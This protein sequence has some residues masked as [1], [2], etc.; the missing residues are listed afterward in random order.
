M[1]KLTLAF[2]A[3]MASFCVVLGQKCGQTTTPMRPNRRYDPEGQR[4]VGGVEAR[5]GSHPWIVSMQQYGSHFCGGTLIRVSDKKEQSDIVVT[6]A[7]CVYDGTSRLEVVAGAHDLDNKYSTG[8]Q[9]VKAGTTKYHPAYNSDTTMNDIAIIKLDTPIN[10]TS[11]VQPACL[12]AEEE[13]VADNTQATVAGWGLTREGGAYSSNILMQVGVP[14]ISSKDCGSQYKASGIKI[15]QSAM[16]CAGYKQ[17]G[18][19]A[20][21]GDSGGPFVVQ[22]ADKGYTLQGVVSFGVG[23]AR[24]GLPGVYT[25]V[26]TYR[27]WIN[28][29]I[30]LNSQVAKA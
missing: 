24:P 1:A 21:Q 28:T 18:K 10:F 2:I 11:T 3:L 19:D 17:G 20:C 30:R 29:Y 14:T 13:T 25:R 23:C 26:A 5:P 22:N 16:I 27:S 8:L 9:R 4:I 6:A 15:D 12:P 7:H